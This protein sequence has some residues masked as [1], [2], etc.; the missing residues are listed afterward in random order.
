MMDRS[1]NAVATAEGAD[2]PAAA[3]MTTDFYLDLRGESCPYPVIHSLE[4][5]SELERGQRIEIVSDCPQAFRNIPDEATNV[6][7]RMLSEPVRDGAQMSFFIEKGEPFDTRR[8]VRAAK[9]ANKA[10]SA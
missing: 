4:A 2:A 9:A 7:S 10:R 5:L 8:A 6:G 1:A 3:P